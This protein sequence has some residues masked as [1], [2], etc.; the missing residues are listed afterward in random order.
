MPGARPPARLRWL[1]T[2]AVIC[3]RFPGYRLHDFEG[4]DAVPIVPI[5]QAMQ[6]LDAANKVHNPPKG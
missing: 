3:Q 5:L 2:R 1:Y 4:P 6:L